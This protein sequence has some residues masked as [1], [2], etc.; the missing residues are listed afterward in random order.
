[1]HQKSPVSSLATCSR[2]WQYFDSHTGKKENTKSRA[3]SSGKM[4]FELRRGFFFYYWHAGIWHKFAVYNKYGV[5]REGQR[6]LS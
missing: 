2:Y 1:M 4:E 3:E 6:L 5:S